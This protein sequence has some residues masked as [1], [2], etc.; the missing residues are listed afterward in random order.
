LLS[1]IFL[2]NYA[3][4]KHLISLLLHI[5]SF[6]LALLT[7]ETAVI[8][9]I[10]Y[11]IYYHFILQRTNPGIKTKVQTRFPPVL[12][13]CWLAPIILFFL[14]RRAVLGTSVGLPLSFTLE[15]F[16][17]NLPAIIQ[18]IGKMLLPFNLSTFP[19]L[20]NSLLIYGAVTIVLICFLLIRSKNIR[21][22]YVVF[23][24]CWL[25]LFLLPA[26]LRTASDYESVF[27]EHR[28]YFPLIGFLLLC[29]ETDLVKNNP[30]E[31]PVFKIAL[32]YVL[33]LFAV[34][35]F[36]HAKDYKDEYSY[37]SSAVS[38]SPD[39]S[40]AHRA[41]G[42]Y[43]QS[44]GQNA[45]AQQEY[46]AA[47]VL[48]PD[49]KEV[50]NNSRTY[51]L[52]AGQYEE[53]EKLFND[54]LK[55]NPDNA[56]TLYN[57]GLVRLNQKKLSE[58]ESLIRKSLTLDPNYLDAQNDLCVVL[59]MEQKYEE[60]IKLCIA[61]LE[62]HPEYESA[63]KNVALIFSAWKDEARVK[64]YSEVLREKGILVN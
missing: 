57:L 48:N 11:F 5:L 64:Y 59:A 54:E 36:N 46:Q 62:S 31:R 19:I 27:L 16:F 21:K 6:F 32:G 42:T 12:I 2:A 33:V 49:L 56:V 13:I 37:W 22:E 43:F 8:L 53:A 26:L 23:G 24:A 17:K 1:L 9:P 39:A 25:M 38:S 18:Y 51:F 29:M 4:K 58:A 20:K 28:A 34:I 55:I 7:K 40:F 35:N 50:R 52:N 15:N 63:K 30:A 45:D 60:A 44:K 10:L 3:D 47:L 61:I 14:V 41:L